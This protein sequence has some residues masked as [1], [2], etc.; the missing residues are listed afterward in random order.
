M[1]EKYSVVSV[2]AQVNQDDIVESPHSKSSGINWHSETQISHNMN[3]VLLAY[4]PSEKDLNYLLINTFRI[5]MQFL[6]SQ[7][8]YSTYCPLFH[9]HSFALTAVW[10]DHGNSIPISK[11]VMQ[12]RQPKPDMTR[13]RS[14]FLV[15]QTIAIV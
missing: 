11:E 9:L 5:Y 15:L 13:Q 12:E 7:S 8:A 10:V 1:K 4:F 14:N 2:H 3:I 6:W